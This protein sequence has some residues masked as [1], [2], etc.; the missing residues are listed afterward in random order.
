MLEQG[1]LVGRGEVSFTPQ[2]KCGKL[3]QKQKKQERKQ[4]KLKIINKKDEKNDD[5]KSLQNEEDVALTIAM[6][7]KYQYFTES[8]EEEEEEYDHDP[9]LP[10]TNL[11]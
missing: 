9:L 8:E 7:E 5:W 6:A 11:I 10:D 2:Y 1:S 3:T 4:E